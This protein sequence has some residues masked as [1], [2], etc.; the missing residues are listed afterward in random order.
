MRER[1]TDRL[2]LTIKL[3]PP[4]QCQ[5]MEHIFRSNH[6]ISLWLEY[7]PT[8]RCI[9]L[10]H[11]FGW[12]ISGACAGFP[13][14]IAGRPSEQKRDPAS[15]PKSKAGVAERWA[16]GPIQPAYWFCMAHIVV[17]YTSA[18]LPPCLLTLFEI[19]SVILFHR[20]HTWRLSI[21]CLRPGTV[22]SYKQ[23]LKSINKI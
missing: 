14:P 22:A 1:E 9:V 20:D 8:K 11:L 19:C 7:H 13:V 15:S 18:F 5:R 10:V 3:E 23:Q 17:E 6:R 16:V 2:T 4:G 21:W 12:S